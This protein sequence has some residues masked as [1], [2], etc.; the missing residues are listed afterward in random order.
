MKP[1]AILVKMNP[2]FLIPK[3]SSNS[4]HLSWDIH[5][6]V[7]R[8]TF[9]ARL[10]QREPGQFVNRRRSCRGV[11]FEF[12]ETTGGEGPDKI[13]QVPHCVPTIL[14][15]LSLQP[16]GKERDLEKQDLCAAHQIEESNVE[17][18]RN[19]GEG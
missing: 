14:C 7:R 18:I 6:I 11:R 1:R 4:F 8:L 17:K 13:D 5:A 3:T 15:V 16:E 10:G 9:A 12:N 19:K 2:S